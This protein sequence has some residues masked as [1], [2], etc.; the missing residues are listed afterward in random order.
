MFGL[1]D[2]RV[3]T[4]LRERYPVPAWKVLDTY[5]MSKWHVKRRIIST[6]FKQLQ[7]TSIN[8]WWRCE[9]IDQV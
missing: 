9:D 4:Y 3:Y 1:Y 8:S 6:F 2:V 5:G 7:Y